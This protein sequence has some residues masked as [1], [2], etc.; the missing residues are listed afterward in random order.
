MTSVRETTKTTVTLLVFA[1]GVALLMRWCG[2]LRGAFFFQMKSLLHSRAQIGRLH[3][4]LISLSF[5]LLLTASC[6]EAVYNKRRGVN[7]LGSFEF[8]MV[9]SA[10]VALWGIAATSVRVSI[11]WFWLFYYVGLMICVRITYRRISSIKVAVPDGN[12]GNVSAVDRAVLYF[13][14]AV[15]LADGFALLISAVQFFVQHK[16]SLG[17]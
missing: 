14:K 8:P 16:Q 13:A 7:A 6:I 12:D 10:C 15:M 2:T 9:F 17:L 1:V 11:P 5:R 4:F 3:S